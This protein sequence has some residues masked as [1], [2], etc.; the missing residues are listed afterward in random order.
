MQVLCDVHIS[1]KIVRFFEEH[2]ISA[3]HINNL[4][5]GSETADKEIA[6]YAD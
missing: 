6:I 1:Y 3:L 5:Q 4:L 2:G